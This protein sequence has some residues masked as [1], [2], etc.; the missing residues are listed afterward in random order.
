MLKSLVHF[1]RL[2]LIL[3]ENVTH[4]EFEKK[5]ERANAAKFWEYRDGTV[6]ITELP[7]GDHECAHGEFTRQ[8]LNAFSNLPLQDQVRNTG[9]TSIYFLGFSL[10]DVYYYIK[11][12][13]VVFSLLYSRTW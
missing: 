4:N 8:F 11:P 10:R 3:V 1:I 9:A 7:K 13:S 12:N 5:S 6:I 2:P